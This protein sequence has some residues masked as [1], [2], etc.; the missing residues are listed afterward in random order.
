MVSR[1][2][3]PECPITHLY[4]MDNY[5]VSSSC[6]LITPPFLI[7]TPPAMQP[8]TRVVFWEDAGKIKHGFVQG[9]D[10]VDVRVSLTTLTSHFTYFTHS[11]GRSCLYRC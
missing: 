9:V 11:G 7:D 5:P 6:P 10:F 3:F 1:P 8:G 2:P 4:C